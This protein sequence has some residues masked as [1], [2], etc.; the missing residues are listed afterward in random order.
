MKSESAKASLLQGQGGRPRREDSERKRAQLLDTAAGMFIREGYARTSMAKLATA[1]KIGK[2]TIYA[3]FG[4]KANLFSKV[5]S[6]IVE[7]HLGAVEDHQ[8]AIDAEEGLKKQLA[9]IIAASTQPMFLGLFRLFLS[10]AHK[11]P[12]IVAAFNVSNDGSVRL[13]VQ[14]LERIARSSTLSVSVDEV[15]NMLLAMANKLVMMESVKLD[16]KSRISP[17]QE[18]GKIVDVV[19]YGVL[20]GGETKRKQTAVGI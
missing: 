19:L 17:G 13:L 6:H 20:R 5:V 9:N 4:N 16:K 3:H 14:H 10:E 12:E 18:A 15:A 7:T 8:E 11:F 1:A 2:P